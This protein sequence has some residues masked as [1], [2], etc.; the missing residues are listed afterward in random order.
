MDNITD[1][2]KETSPIKTKKNLSVPIIRRDIIKQHLPRG[3]RSR[4]LD[5][6]VVGMNTLRKNSRREIN[7]V[8]E[9]K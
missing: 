2:R 1:W 6:G 4:I 8:E 3:W 5:R 9:I 7:R